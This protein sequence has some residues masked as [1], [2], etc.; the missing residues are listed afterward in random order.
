MEAYAPHPCGGERSVGTVPLNEVL[1][2]AFSQAQEE[3]AEEPGTVTT[4]AE[5]AVT[6]EGVFYLFLHHLVICY[7]HCHLYQLSVTLITRKSYKTTP[8]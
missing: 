8:L 4:M 2:D 5:D 1:P 7:L 3:T 6:P